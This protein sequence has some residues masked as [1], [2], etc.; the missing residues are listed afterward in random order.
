[1]E[2]KSIG[3]N[4]IKKF[5]LDFFRS[6]KC[7]IEEFGDLLIIN[8]I[9]EQFEKFS[10]KK[11]PYKLAFR[12]KSSEQEDIEL[13]T[14]GSFLLKAMRD[15]LED[16]GKTSLFKIEFLPNDEEIFKKI[17]INEDY[18]VK[19]P[20]ISYEGFTKFSFL[21]AFQYLN[22]KEQI[23]T[24]IC[25]SGE[26]IIEF[27]QEKYNLIEGRK[28][29][30]NARELNFEYDIAK[31]KLR[32]ILSSKIDKIS[33]EL[34]EKL[35]VEIKRVEK[36]H[37]AQINEIDEE[38]EKIKNELNEVE[39]QLVKANDKD[40]MRLIARRIKLKENLKKAEENFEI[41]SKI[42]SE[43]NFFINDEKHKH[44]LNIGNKLINTSVIY[45]PI[46]SYT[47]E[48]NKNK[49]RREIIIE[50]D[51]FKEIV[52]EINCE[53][54]GEKLSEISMCSGGHIVSNKFIK[55]CLSCMKEVCPKCQ[56]KTC[57]ISGKETCKDC[58][59]KCRNCSKNILKDYVKMNNL[60]GES[61]CISC[62]TR[63][64]N[65]GEYSDKSRFKKSENY[66]KVVCAKCLNKHFFKDRFD[67]NEG[68]KRLSLNDF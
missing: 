26:E 37:E 49:I 29:E 43:K 25:I 27:D 55:N 64:E 10:G 45:Y 28:G 32:E 7:Q 46:F 9:P 2:K 67:K 6:L 62:L 22:E 30:Y 4:E 14:S 48:I 19:K 36:H 42:E 16:R 3:E 51:P 58:V 33:K 39:N 34:H 53:I 50:F 15:Y 56:K 65:C 12:A 23:I 66:G 63:C 41:K 31:N 38:Y 21:T 13:V 35:E 47:L 60:S 8:N 18:L 17:K 61:G 68:M 1:M 52:S 40:R 59:E 24:P 5:S 44:S 54:S 11:G 20:R 57:E